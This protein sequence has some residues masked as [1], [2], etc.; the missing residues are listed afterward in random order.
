M[1]EAITILM[2]NQLEAFLERVLAVVLLADKR[3]QKQEQSLFVVGLVV[4]VSVDKRDRVVWRHT[5]SFAHFGERF[6]LLST[7]SVQI[8]T[9]V[10][11]GPS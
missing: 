6:K 3:E 4:V 10:Q 1:S 2:V 7:A 9:G 11:A 8:C 5:R